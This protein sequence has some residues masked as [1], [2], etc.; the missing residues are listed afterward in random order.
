MDWLTTIYAKH[1]KLS[2]Q[3]NEKYFDK[4]TIVSNHEEIENG[5]HIT[6]SIWSITPSPIQI[7]NSAIKK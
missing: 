1:E 5:S 6:Q 3:Q 4:L 2:F 7:E